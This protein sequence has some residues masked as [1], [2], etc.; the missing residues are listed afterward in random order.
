[1]K[2]STN[3]SNFKIVS[4]GSRDEKQSSPELLFIQN[5]GAVSETSLMS[6]RAA[7]PFMQVLEQGTLGSIL[8]NAIRLESKLDPL[9]RGA[10]GQV[11][12]AQPCRASFRAPYYK[13]IRR[14]VYRSVTALEAEIASFIQRHNADPK[15]FRWTNQPM[16]SLLPLGASAA[17]MPRQRTTP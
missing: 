2:A 11:G 5:F 1:M 13:K 14:G 17:R 6:T 15:L 10:K 12:M 8:D 3:L 7:R 16:T 9:R 4:A